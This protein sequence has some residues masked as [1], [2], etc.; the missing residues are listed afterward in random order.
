[1][2]APLCL[3]WW[4]GRSRGTS[5]APGALCNVQ[6]SVQILRSQHCRVTTD[7]MNSGFITNRQAGEPG[8]PA[9]PWPSG[10]RPCAGRRAILE[11]P[12]QIP[13]QTATGGGQEIAKR[14]RRVVYSTETTDTRWGRNNGHKVL[15][16]HSASW[17]LVQTHWR[18]LGA[19]RAMPPKDPKW[20]GWPPKRL[21][22]VFFFYS[23]GLWDRHIG[24]SLN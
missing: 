17:H 14:W 19:F 9:G 13:R 2:A 24:T 10:V 16:G 21:I 5:P 1:M 22:V 11:S 20:A 12:A 4:Q 23:F 15:L 7:C 6:D 3:S 8:C 18:V